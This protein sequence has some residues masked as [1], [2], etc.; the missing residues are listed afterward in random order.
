VLVQRV[1][2]ILEL[3][4]DFQGAPRMPLRG[5]RQEALPLAAPDEAPVQQ[6]SASLD[7]DDR[8]AALLGVAPIGVDDLI[9]HCGLP[10]GVVQAALIDMEL[11]GTLV[12][13]AGGRVSRVV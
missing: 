2:D 6:S 4:T 5:A 9:R 7:T 12:R 8:I 11:S 1:E 13:H 3:L 10:A